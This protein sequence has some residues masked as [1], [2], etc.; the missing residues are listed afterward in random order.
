MSIAS[1]KEREFK[2]REQLILKTSFKML[3]YEGYIGFTID[4]LAKKIDY[5]KGT[6]YK[7]FS[8]K[9]DILMKILLDSSEQRLSIIDRAVDLDLPERARLIVSFSGDR[10]YKKLNPNLHKIMLIARVESIWNKV[11]RDI[12]LAY[13]EMLQ[14]KYLRFDQLLAKALASGCLVL[15]GHCSAD[16]FF[17]LLSITIGYSSLLRGGGS[18]NLQGK[19]HDCFIDS[20]VIQDGDRA[21]S[22]S[23][24]TYLDGLNWRPLSSE[25]DY[26]AL[27]EEAAKTV[28][29]DLTAML[30]KG[31]VF[32]Y[33]STNL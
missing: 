24:N 23:L 19:F 16:I 10:I 7:H 21:L 11:S 31:E 27:E 9:E 18:D 6:V 22:L 30:A 5:A 12:K 32:E 29:S 26:F 25:Y 1:R 15:N 20:L 17:T 33:V 4:K 14:R 13:D 8:C 28:Y 2:D 3:L